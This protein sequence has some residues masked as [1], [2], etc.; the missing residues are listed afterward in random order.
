MRDAVDPSLKI[1]IGELPY[2]PNQ[3]MHL[4]ADISNLVEDTGFIPEYSFEEGISET[5]E[6]VKRRIALEK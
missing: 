6:W 3:V 5:V 1:G 4:E 2:Y